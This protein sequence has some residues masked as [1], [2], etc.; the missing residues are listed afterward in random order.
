[1]VIK[2]IQ[3]NREEHGLQTNV[4]CSSS[5]GE[6]ADAKSGGATG[7][8]QNALGIHTVRRGV[9]SAHWFDINDVCAFEDP[10]VSIPICRNNQGKHGYNMKQETFACGSNP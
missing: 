10:S 5:D 2:V 4:S 9:G 3:N 8:S 7:L 6:L 1:M